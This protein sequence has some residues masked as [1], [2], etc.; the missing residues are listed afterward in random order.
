MYRSLPALIALFACACTVGTPAT[1][2]GRDGGGSDGGNAF[3]PDADGDTICDADEG[4]GDADGDG[5]PNTMDEDS[6][7]D[8]GGRQ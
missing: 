7:G 2:P 4:A 3:C 5:I 1:I 8:R 6:D